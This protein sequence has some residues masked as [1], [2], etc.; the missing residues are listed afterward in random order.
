M[1]IFFSS[2]LSRTDIV[3]FINSGI[4]VSSVIFDSNIKEDRWARGHSYTFVG[5]TAIA[6]FLGII[7]GSSVCSSLIMKWKKKVIKKFV[8]LISLCFSGFPFTAVFVYEFED[9]NFQI[10]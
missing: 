5:L 1:V 7:L 4:V 10:I 3:L 2:A 9:I 8:F 6:Y